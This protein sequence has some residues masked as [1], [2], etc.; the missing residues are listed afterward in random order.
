MLSA[1]N[2]GRSRGKTHA[3]CTGAYMTKNAVSTRL[4]PGEPTDDIPGG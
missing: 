3:E 1:R 2:G 4:P